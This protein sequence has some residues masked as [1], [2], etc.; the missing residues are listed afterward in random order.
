MECQ[1][2]YSYEFGRDGARDETAADE[3]ENE[4]DRKKNS[5]FPS[6]HRSRGVTTQTVR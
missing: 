5:A 3:D 2:N 6:V 4:I 1:T